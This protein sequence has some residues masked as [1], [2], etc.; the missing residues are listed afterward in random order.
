MRVFTQDYYKKETVLK[1]GLLQ[2]VLFGVHVKEK[3]R[4]AFIASRD[5][6]SPA[7]FPRSSIPDQA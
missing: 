7:P 4:Q 5:K 1:R 2:L 6:K 3:E